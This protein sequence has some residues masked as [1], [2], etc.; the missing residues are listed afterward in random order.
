MRRLAIALFAC[1]PAVTAPAP[2]APSVGETKGEPPPVVAEPTWSALPVPCAKV[3]AV[4]PKSPAPQWSARASG[5]AEALNAVHGR[6]DDVTIVGNAGVV[7]RTTDGGYSME[8]CTLPEDL[9]AVAV[10]AD[11][12][13][14]I[15]GEK[16]L[17]RRTSK[18]WFARSPATGGVSS[19]SAL[20]RDDVWI[21][22]DRKL[23]LHATADGSKWKTDQHCMHTEHVWAKSANELYLECSFFVEQSL[24]GGATWASSAFEPHVESGFRIHGAANEIWIAG[25]AGTL[26][27]SF[28]GGATFA[29]VPAPAAPGFFSVWALGQGRAIVV[30]AGLHT[31]LAK[32]WSTELSD[33]VGIAAV[34]ASSAL[35]VWAVGRAGTVLHRP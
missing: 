6:G 33:D 30:G 13:A 32:T 1:T 19:L 8:R 25:T 29:P 5:T 15:G 10:V 7:L 28:D 11:G 18:G 26:D 20:S 17:Y 16:N 9:H 3:A 21:V 22:A 14:W 27:A 4:S 31:R 2:V 24:D 23:L 35:D 34:W 12:E